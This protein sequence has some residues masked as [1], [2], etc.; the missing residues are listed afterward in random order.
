M[1]SQITSNFMILKYDSILAVFSNNIIE[2]EVLSSEVASFFSEICLPI[3]SSYKIVI[4]HW[5]NF[6]KLLNFF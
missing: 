5:F 6:C 4:N 3:F 1:T 2:F